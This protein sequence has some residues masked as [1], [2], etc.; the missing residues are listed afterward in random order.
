M[1]VTP[2]VKPGR[3]H[4]QRV[5]FFFF[6]VLFPSGVSQP[7]SCLHITQSPAPS[8]LTP[9]NFMSSFTTSVT[10]LFGFEI[11][12][13]LNPGK[14]R[15]FHSYWNHSMK[16]QTDYDFTNLQPW[17]RAAEWGLKPI[18]QQPPA[19]SFGIFIS[20]TKSATGSWHRFRQCVPA[21]EGWHVVIFHDHKYPI[22]GS[23]QIIAMIGFDAF[24]STSG[25]IRK[26][27]FPSFN[28][29]IRFLFREGGHKNSNQPV[30]SCCVVLVIVVLASSC[31]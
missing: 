26:L 7:I 23:N 20:K 11:K 22:T 17:I 24:T 4:S 1:E 10:L 9:T 18:K 25:I 15:Y 2:R 27:C 31:W 5:I 6:S 14:L 19:A 29:F 28:P 3:L 21:E 12:M 30:L 13:L 8:S 16:L